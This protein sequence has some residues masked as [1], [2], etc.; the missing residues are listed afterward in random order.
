[1]LN[2]NIAGGANLAGSGGMTVSAG[3]GVSIGGHAIPPVVPQSSGLN[4]AANSGLRKIAVPSSTTTTTTTTIDPAFAASHAKPG[5]GDMWISKDDYNK[6]NAAEQATYNSTGYD[7][8]T[9]YWQ[10]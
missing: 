9:L 5:A 7:G 2:E 8:L 3:S 4:K 6:L 10:A 1:M